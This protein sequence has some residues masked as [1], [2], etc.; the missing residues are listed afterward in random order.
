M[1]I[2]LDSNLCPHEKL[3][4]TRNDNHTDKYKREQKCILS[5]FFYSIFERQLHKA[6]NVSGCACSVLRC[7]LSDNK[8][9][10]ERGGNRVI[11]ARVFFNF[12]FFKQSF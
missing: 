12:Y 4:S 7:N 5:L 6:I 10:K 1:E 8:G 11:Q 9:T 2:T 3:S